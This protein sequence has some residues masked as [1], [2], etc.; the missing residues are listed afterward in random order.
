MQQRSAKLLTDQNSFN[1]FELFLV[2]TGGHWNASGV[3]ARPQCPFAFQLDPHSRWPFMLLTVGFCLWSSKET[4]VTLPVELHMLLRFQCNCEM[5][6][7]MYG[8][9][10][11]LFDAGTSSRL[12]VLGCLPNLCPLSPYGS[13]PPPIITCSRHFKRQCGKPVQCTTKFGCI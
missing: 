1:S 12:C 2:C 13:Q 6:S 5:S 8:S 9:K 11:R 3:G 7:D 10:G 4:K